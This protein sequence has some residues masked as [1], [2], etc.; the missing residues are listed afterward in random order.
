[1]AVQAGKKFQADIV[2]NGVTYICLNAMNVYA[3]DALAPNPGTDY[4]LAVGDYV[5]LVVWHNNGAT[6]NTIVSPNRS[7]E[8]MMHRI[9]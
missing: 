9:G 2:L 5:E 4:E 8:F 1:M 7:T 3:A 6:T